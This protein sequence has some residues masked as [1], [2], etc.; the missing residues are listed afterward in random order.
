M[1]V[2]CFEIKTEADSN[3]ITLCSDDVKPSTGMFTVSD[4]CGL[5]VTSG[6]LPEPSNQLIHNRCIDEEIKSNRTQKPT[7][8]EL[9]PNTNLLLKAL[10][11]QTSNNPNR[12]RTQNFVFFSISSCSLAKS[13]PVDVVKF[14]CHVA[15]NVPLNILSENSLH[16]VKCV[17]YTVHS[18][19]SEDNLRC[20]CVVVYHK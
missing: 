2:Q 18:T 14:F 1:E 8:T 9:E 17:L 10:T 6:A 15:E 13:C 5:V 19:F 11:T 3:D 7:F 16:D 4:S 12:T 20:N